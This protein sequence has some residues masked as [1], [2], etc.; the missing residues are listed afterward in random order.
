MTKRFITGAYIP[1]PARLTLKISGV[2]VL[3][4]RLENGQARA[5]KRAFDTV[6]ASESPSLHDR[7]VVECVIA[8]L[9][10]AA[11]ENSQ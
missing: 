7:D 8:S 5:L 6:K 3:D 10:L 1:R 4:V 9:L 2:K 11:Q